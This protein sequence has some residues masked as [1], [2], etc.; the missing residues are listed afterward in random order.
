MR[1]V[2]RPLLYVCAVRV[3]LL[4]VVLYLVPVLV[5]F[6]VKFYCTIRRMLCL[7]FVK[8]RMNESINR[9]IPN[10]NQ[11]NPSVANQSIKEKNERA[12]E[13]SVNHHQSIS[14]IGIVRAK[15]I[16]P[17]KQQCARSTDQPPRSVRSGFFASISVASLRCWARCF[18]LQ[19]EFRKKFLPGGC[20]RAS[21]GID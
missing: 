19:S 17:K 14:I 1:V 8:E 13:E 9:S 6:I 2:Y 10:Q 5:K 16:A 15:K 21:R 18:P 4:V 11:N 12:K 7:R 20:Q 3:Y